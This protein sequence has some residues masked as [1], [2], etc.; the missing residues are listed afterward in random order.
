MKKIFLSLLCGALLLAVGANEC[1]AV[2]W[3]MAH[4]RPVTD[5]V[6]KNLEVFAHEVENGT[7]GRVKIQIYPAG[8]LGGGDAVFEKVAMGSVEMLCGWMNPTLDEKLEVY[9]IPGFVNNYEDISKMY[10]VGSPYMNILS[11][12]CERLG[13]KILGSYAQYMAGCAFVE[14]PNEPLNPNA[15]HNE[16][17]R[18][19][20]AR[21]HAYIWEGLGYKA[22]P[23]AYAEILPSLQTG[24][25]DGVAT[26]GAETTYILLRDT[27]KYWLPANTNY[28]PWFIMINSD[29][30]NSISPEDQAVVSDAAKKLEAKRWVDAPKDMAYWEQELRDQGIKVYELTDEQLDAFQT[31]IREYVIPKLRNDL[32]AEFIDEVV[33]SINKSLGN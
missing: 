2:T 19:L 33:E 22:T 20:A 31:R 15:I 5:N 10:A 26:I 7:D 3:K 27:A 32:G 21:T 23:I 12:L 11:E 24:V 1:L 16:K 30:W 14:E 18:I 25:I 4:N 28:E 6:Q 8:Q 9:I 13:I 17:V 29:A